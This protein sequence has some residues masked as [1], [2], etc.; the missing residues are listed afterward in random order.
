MSSRWSDLARASTATGYVV[1]GSIPHETFKAL[2]LPSLVAG[3]RM[4]VGVFRAEFSRGGDGRI[5]EEWISWVRPGTE[6]PDF[7]VSS[8]FGW[9]ERGE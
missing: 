3:E 8:A 1:E 6:K 7:H 4:Q 9:F 2:G 5:V